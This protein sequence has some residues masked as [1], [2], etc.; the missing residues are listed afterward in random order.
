MRANRCGYRAALANRAFVYHSG[1]GSFDNAVRRT[2]L[3]ASNTETLCRRYPEYASAVDQYGSGAHYQAERLLGALLPDAQ[4]RL[5]VLFDFSSAGPSHNGTF[6]AGAKIL[7]H[8]TREWRPFFKVHVMASDAA[9]RFHALDNIPGLSFASPDTTQTFAAAFRFGQPFRLDHLTSMA[10]LALVNVYAMLDPISYDCLHLNEADLGVIWASVFAHADG[11]MYISDTVAEQFR[12]RFRRREGLGELVCP[13]SL[14][15]RDYA[16]GGR[17][18][19]T[20]GEYILVIGNSFA[21]K[22]IKPTVAALREAFPALPIAVLGLNAADLPGVT[23]WPSGEIPRAQVDD[24]FRRAKCVVFPSLYEG[25]GM[26]I[27]EALAHR[28]PVLA[29]NLTVIREIG[30]KCGVGENLVLYDSTADLI[31]LLRQSIPEWRESCPELPDPVHGWADV[32]SRLGGFLRERTAKVSYQ[33]VTLPRLEH[34]WALECMTG[35]GQAASATNRA[36]SL[37]RALY[38]RDVQIAALRDSRSWKIT[39]PLRG[40][41]SLYLRLTRRA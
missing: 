27:L 40:L 20:P 19:S 21:H 36:S 32:A 4:G 28:K 13:L 35:A 18:A 8:A 25:F 33:N 5:A 10:R 1:S 3:Q 14:D 2:R 15:L 26:P 24:L 37:V 6:D 39:A 31:A 22:Y 41:G 23:A 7:R 9:R 16:A 30:Q 29:R 34:L 11:V 12:T 17:R 38:D